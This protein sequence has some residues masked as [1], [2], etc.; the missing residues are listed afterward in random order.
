MFHCNIEGIDNEE[1][2]KVCVEASTQKKV[3]QKSNTG[4]TDVP[5]DGANKE[6][7]K[8]RKTIKKVM[9]EHIDH[10]LVEAE[11]WTHVLQPGETTMIHTH[12]NKLDW[13]FL[14]LSWVYY[15]KNIQTEID[16]VLSPDL[17]DAQV[18]SLFLDEASGIP[19]TGQD[20]SLKDD[21]PEPRPYNFSGKIIFQTQIG[22]T[23]V[24]NYDVDPKPGDFI[25]FPSWLPHFT[26]RNDGSEPRVSISGNYYIQNEKVYNEA[27]YDAK[28]NIKKLTGFY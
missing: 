8:L 20:A 7:K 5:V 28:S 4:Y 6:I 2:V 16:W 3:S 19:T 15:A 26:T 13:A 10:R 21:W 11:M 12:R 25:V 9:H 24:I 17:D 22:G 1:L 18:K 14:G 23:K 27:A